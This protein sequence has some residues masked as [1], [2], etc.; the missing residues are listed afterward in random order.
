MTAPDM[1]Q[2][3][4]DFHHKFGFSV[5]IPFGENADILQKRLMILEEEMREFREAVAEGDQPHILK[6][7]CDVLYALHGFAVCY[8]LPVNEGFERVHASN[9]SKSRPE[10]V[11]NKAVK[12]PGYFNAELDDLFVKPNQTSKSAA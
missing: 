3:V 12:G 1:R 9:M 6:E 4:E 10:G 5:G 2:M 7:M 8:G 11:D